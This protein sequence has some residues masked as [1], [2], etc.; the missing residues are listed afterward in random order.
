MRGELLTHAVPGDN[1]A[2]SRKQSRPTPVYEGGGLVI[3]VPPSTKTFATRLRRSLQEF[4]KQ[5]KDTENFQNHRHAERP[6]VLGGAH[7]RP[8]LRDGGDRRP[9]RRSEPLPDHLSCQLAATDA[10][11]GTEAAP[12]EARA[13]RVL[14]ARTVPHHSGW[15]RR[16]SAQPHT[17]SHPRS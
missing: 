10:A 13:H 7:R 4:E 16:G 2:N 6:G 12:R 15:Q 11:G 8:R 1:R 3:P 5:L 17:A 9:G 14:A